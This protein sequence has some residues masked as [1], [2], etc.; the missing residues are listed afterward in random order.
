MSRHGREE[1]RWRYLI[2]SADGLSRLTETC[3]IVWCPRAARIAEIPFPR[4]KQLRRG[5]EQSLDQ[6]HRGAPE[7]GAGGEPSLVIERDG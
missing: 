4:D 6:S 2:D 3:E 5:I 7:H 1:T